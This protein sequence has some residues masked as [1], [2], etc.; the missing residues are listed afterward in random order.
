M[1]WEPEVVN[2]LSVST[3]SLCR[4]CSTHIDFPLNPLSN[5]S[6]AHSVAY[7]P[8]Y[9]WAV[10][11]IAL[12]D[13]ND[14]HVPS[15]VSPKASVS[16]TLTNSSDDMDLKDFSTTPESFYHI[17][18]NIPYNKRDS[19][20]DSYDKPKCKV[21]YPKTQERKQLARSLS[22]RKKSRSKKSRGDSQTTLSRSSSWPSVHLSDSQEALAGQK[23]STPANAAT[24][25]LHIE[26]PSEVKDAKDQ[27]NSPKRSEAV[28]GTS[29]NK[30]RIVQRS[31]PTKQYATKQFVGRVGAKFET[32]V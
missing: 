11:E 19:Q 12:D 8:T 2:G 3:Q 7:L 28:E 31:T 29:V 22:I 4:R 10:T 9:E 18:P 23:T 32:D 24:A 21:A 6:R 26:S 25:A 16:R 1:S 5:E 30:S 17:V 15:Y 27:H 14:G 20:S 13:D